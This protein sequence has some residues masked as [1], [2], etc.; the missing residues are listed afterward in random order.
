MKK[1]SFSESRFGQL[2]ASTRHA[3]L[4][5]GCD[6]QSAIISPYDI[7]LES[8]LNYA[9]NHFRFKVVD[10]MG[11]YRHITEITL[12]PEDIFVFDQWGLYLLNTKGDLDTEFR[13]L[14]FPDVYFFKDDEVDAGGVIYNSKLSM[15]VNNEV[16]VTNV[17][18]DIFFSSMTE[19]ERDVHE[20]SSFRYVE[21]PVLLDGHKNIFFCMDLPKGIDLRESTMRVR[22]R[23]RGLLVRNARPITRKTG[24]K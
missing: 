2:C 3:L 6:L 9:S 21:M 5:A 14:T 18:T 20:L 12:H 11:A 10:F 19:Q 13:E 1:E 7:I 23:L 24:T 22:L 17:P 8:R 15:V 16:V 4:S